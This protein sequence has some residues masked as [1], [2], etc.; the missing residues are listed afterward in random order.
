MLDG[1]E[2]NAQSFRVVTKLALSSPLIPGL[3]LTRASLNALLKYPWTQQSEGHPKKYGAYR[4]EKEDLDFARELQPTAGDTR[5]SAEAE[6]VDWADDVTYGVYDVEDFYR[7]RLIPLDRLASLDDDS[8]RRRLFDGMYARPEL[9]KLIG[10]DPRHE[11]EETFLRFI[12]AFPISEP[13]TGTHEQRS[14]LRWMSSV[15]IEQSARAIELQRPADNHQAFVKIMR[16]QNLAVRLQ[17]AMIWFY[18]IYNPALGT[19]QYGQRKIIRELVDIFGNAAVSGKD[20]ERN[21]IPSA[22]RNQLPEARSDR[23]SAA[24]VVA[25]I[26]ASMTEQELVKL[27]RRLTGIDFS[28]ILNYGH[29][30]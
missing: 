4:S 15:L 7:A 3:N 16:P 10:E 18:V 2:G 17:K 24:R 21:I 25:D 8:E 26:I 19:Q 6:I 12:T 22:F 11:L 1:F 14:R 9:K 20:E 13:Y 23:D 28:S 27:Y 29:G 30:N 5:R